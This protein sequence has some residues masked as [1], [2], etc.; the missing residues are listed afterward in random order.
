V[1]PTGKAVPSL[2]A[3]YAPALV[4]VVIASHLVNSLTYRQNEI[5][6]EINMLDNMFTRDVSAYEIRTLIN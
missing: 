4:M 3:K 1:E 2:E 6:L 5:E